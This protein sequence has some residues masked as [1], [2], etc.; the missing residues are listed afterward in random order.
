MNTPADFSALEQAFARQ[1]GEYARLK[2]ILMGLEPDL[3]LEVPVDWLRGLAEATDLVP[4][5]APPR[6]G[7]R[8]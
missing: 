4:A 8:A 2:N 3:S 7:V 1:H 5:P 6:A